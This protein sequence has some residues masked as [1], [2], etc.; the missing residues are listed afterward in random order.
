MKINISKCIKIREM[1]KITVNCFSERKP[2]KVVFQFSKEAIVGFASE[3][4]RIYDDIDDRYQLKLETHP[5]GDDPAPS[6]TVGFFLTSDSPMFYLKINS[7]PKEVNS[8]RINTLKYN[9]ILYDNIKSNQ[10]FYV[11]TAGC[12]SDELVVESYELSKENIVKITV[13]DEINNDISDE[14]NV[15]TFEINHEGILDL[16]TMLLVW[17]NNI[18]SN[19]YSLIQLNSKKTGFNFG[20]A[21]TE[22]SIHTSFQVKQLG[23]AYDY[24]FNW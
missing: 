8:E 3:L 14:C 1:C 4:I 18:S 17:A 23:S 19:D 22:D 11:D 24:G 16:A 5:L 7:L 15:L 20:I 12:D 21:L 13:Y 2:D 10:Y 9:E 6:Q